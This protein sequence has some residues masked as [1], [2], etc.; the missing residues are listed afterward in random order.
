MET[1]SIVSFLS[2]V[3]VLAGLG[4]DNLLLIELQIRSLGL[5]DKKHFLAR[6]IA[7]VLAALIRVGM[8][9]Q[10]S[11]FT[12]LR[13][14]LPDTVLHRSISFI[15]H[16]FGFV[17][18]AE[19]HYTYLHVLYLV[20]GF[21]VFVVAFWEIYSKWR[22]ASLAEKK[23]SQSS[24]SLTTGKIIWVTSYLLLMNVLFSA[25]SV[26][27]TVAMLDISSQFGLMVGAISVASL[28]MIFA[29]V[30]LSVFIAK[31]RHFA[32]AMLVTLVV[33]AAKLGMDGFGGHFPN[34]FLLFIIA[35]IFTNDFLQ[36]AIDK[37]YEG[38]RALDTE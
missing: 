1:E 4:I 35:M 34:G 32:V 18:G 8:L 19:H 37:R 26:F 20:G 21:L 23:E 13:D 2:L 25:D 10:L 12:W 28:L 6:S 22:H 15:G 16:V 29:S 24:S 14:E 5:D 7:L 17:H 33:I 3:F 38:A 27:T 36:G 31:N 11:K 30:P 9:L